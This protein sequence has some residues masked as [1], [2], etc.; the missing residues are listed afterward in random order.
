MKDYKVFKIITHLI[1][2]WIYGICNL[3]V[4]YR[5]IFNEL[6]NNAHER[7]SRRFTLKSFLAEHFSNTKT[8]LRHNPFAALT[9]LYETVWCLNRI[10]YCD[11]RSPSFSIDQ[12]FLYSMCNWVPPK[13]CYHWD[14]NYKHTRLHQGVA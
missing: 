12:I 4:I 2:F 6:C 5:W 11:D 10:K 3:F 1:W 7:L 13:S 8:I 9:N 14:L